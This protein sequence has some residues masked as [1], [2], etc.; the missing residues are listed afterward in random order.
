[1]R[2]LR[3]ADWAARRRSS[4]GS[5]IRLIAFTTDPRPIR[6]ILA[7]LGEPLE[8]PPVSATRG[9]PTDWG[10]FVQAHDDRAIFQGRID[11]LSVI[12]IHSL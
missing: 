11:E 4:H 7:H 10:E 8:P 9:P 3:G 12:D 5:D 1:M 2:R 6:K